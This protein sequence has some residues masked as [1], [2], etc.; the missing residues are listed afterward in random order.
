[1]S[2]AQKKDQVAR[3][4]AS[5]L[6]AQ[7]GC[8]ELINQTT[9]FYQDFLDKDNNK[10]TEQAKKKKNFKKHWAPVR[11]SRKFNTEGEVI[12]QDLLGFK[13]QKSSSTSMGKN[14]TKFKKSYGIPGFEVR[15]DFRASILLVFLLPVFH[16][17]YSPLSEY[18]KLTSPS[19]GLEGKYDSREL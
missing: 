4:K 15:L 7:M 12:T 1:M 3:K 9:I 11:C 6:S 16:P 8:R 10:L 14:I 2:L 19:K 13:R 17:W 5:F 18:L